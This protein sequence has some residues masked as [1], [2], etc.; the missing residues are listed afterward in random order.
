MIDHAALRAQ[1]QYSFSASAAVI[2]A[3]HRLS[4][5]ATPLPRRRDEPGALAPFTRPAPDLIPKANNSDPARHCNCPV[6]I[7]D[8]ALIAPCQ[9]KD[10]K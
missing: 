4:I 5:P 9:R 1:A 2:A 3:C 7:S 6:C 8:C 10:R